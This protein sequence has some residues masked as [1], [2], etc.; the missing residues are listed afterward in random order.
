[1]SEHI[2]QWHNRGHIASGDGDPMD[3]DDIISSSSS[4]AMLPSSNPKPP[5]GFPP[6]CQSDQLPISYK[7][8]Q[9]Q[10]HAQVDE[11]LED[12]PHQ[13][14]RMSYCDESESINN[15]DWQS[16]YKKLRSPN[17]T[18][19][20]RSSMHI[21]RPDPHYTKTKSYTKVERKAFGSD[22]LR[23]AIRIKRLVISAESGKASTKDSFK[24]LLKNNVIRLEEIVGIEHLV[25]G[26]SA[27]KLLKERRDHSRAILRE[28]ERQCLQHKKL[29]HN[30]PMGKLGEFSVNRTLKSV[31]RARIRA[32]MAA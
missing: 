25:L 24:F 5:K 13:R 22:A 27:A 26:K 9:H 15:E 11:L 10:L 31:K 7:Q 30:D 14:R 20:E 6:R 17:V 19:S 21:Y 4:S 2:D 18:F 3:T 16:L 32:A 28:Q 8:Q 1:M 29:K 23:E 12:W